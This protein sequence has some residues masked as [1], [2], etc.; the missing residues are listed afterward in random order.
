MRQDRGFQRIG[1]RLMLSLGMVKREG[2]SFQLEA[3]CMK[4]RHTIQYYISI[5]F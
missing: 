2:S 1:I 3:C 4:K 5:V